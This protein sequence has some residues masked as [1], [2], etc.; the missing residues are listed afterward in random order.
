MNSFKG[1]AQ[2]I[3]KKMILTVVVMN[4]A[5]PAWAKMADVTGPVDAFYKNRNNKL[6]WFADSSGIMLRSR[7]LLLMSHCEEQG[8]DTGKYPISLLQADLQGRKVVTETQVMAADRLYT[9]AAIGYL[10]DLLGSG[11]P[12]GIAHDALLGQEENNRHKQ[13]LELLSGC[14]DSAMLGNAVRG[15]EPATTDYLLLKSALA[16]ALQTRQQDTI[17][18]L[19]M[20]LN[21]YR[22]IYNFHYAKC[23]VVN[24]AS[25][26]LYYY[27]QDSLM[28]GMKVVT[29]KPATPGPRFTAYCNEII[30]YPYWNV[31]RSI[32][33]NELLPLCRKS[34]GVLSFMNIQVLDSRGNVLNPQKINWRLYNRKN[35]PYRFRQATGCDNA[36]GVIKFNLVSPFGVYL[37]DTNNKL[38]FGS[39]KRYFS[40]GC[41]RIEKP[42]ELANFLLGRQLD[43]NFLKAC[44]KEER[45]H[46]LELSAPIPVFVVYVRAG[47]ASGE[48]V[49]YEDVYNLK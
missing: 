34:P 10:E 47:V 46:T 35:F 1:L 45:P 49:Y 11:V 12:N 30:L 42:M 8:L 15:L 17:I 33:V 2:W 41:I 16:K 3:F 19:K 29:G 43:S 32:A 23:I 7:L 21:S 4:C 24:I 6:F 48:I 18:P 36:L 40:H 14:G 31:L 13:T 38:A 25:G 27:E 28:L 37:H 39:N 20:A 5:L 22:R 9:T 44:L 26:L